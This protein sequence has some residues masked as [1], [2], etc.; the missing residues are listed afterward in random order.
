MNLLEPN[1]IEIISLELE[2]KNIQVQA[3]LDLIKE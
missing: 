1:Y 2:M 3:V